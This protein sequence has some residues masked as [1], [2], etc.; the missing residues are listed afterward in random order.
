MFDNNNYRE[1]NCSCKFNKND[2]KVVRNDVITYSNNIS[3]EW[4]RKLVGCRGYFF[5]KGF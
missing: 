5:V 3:G 4:L 1:M 2:K